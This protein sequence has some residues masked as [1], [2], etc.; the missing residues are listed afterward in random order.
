MGQGGDM[1][2]EAKTESSEEDSQ[3]PPPC[4]TDL[5]ISLFLSLLFYCILA[6]NLPKTTDSVYVRYVEYT[7]K[8]RTVAMFVT[9][10]QAIFHKRR[11]SIC[12]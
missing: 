3:S 10:L 8:L 9:D 1:D 12:L 6:K 7:C 11:I 4:Y 2:V 5:Y